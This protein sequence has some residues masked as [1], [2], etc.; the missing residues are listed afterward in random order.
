MVVPA[1]LK[2]LN[3]GNLENGEKYESP[4]FLV[5]HRLYGGVTQLDYAYEVGLREHISRLPK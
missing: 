4:K 2:R 5:T 3:E 1:Q